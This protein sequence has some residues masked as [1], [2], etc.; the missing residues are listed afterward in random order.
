ME[1]RKTISN[2]NQ[3]FYDEK[4]PL[5]K[6]TIH[7]HED[8]KILAERQDI[9]HDMM[10][11]IIEKID[12]L[13]INQNFQQ[14]H[15][16]YQNYYRSSLPATI[17]TTDLSTKN[18][19]PQIYFEK[20]ILYEQEKIYNQ[21][22]HDLTLGET[23]DFFQYLSNFK[24][25]EQRSKNDNLIRFSFKENEILFTNY[26]KN[27]DQLIELITMALLFLKSKQIKKRKIRQ[28]NNLNMI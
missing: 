9:L 4:I 3:Q 21:L 18:F 20:I 5:E 13:S 1:K 27:K 25:N 22:Q 8:H 2:T 23:K 26:R 14:K 24:L 28:N 16:K 6:K 12:H 19:N 11:E 7:L 17:I 10:Q 15:E